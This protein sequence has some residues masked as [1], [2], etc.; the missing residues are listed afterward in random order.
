MAEEWRL[1][2]WPRE[3]GGPRIAESGV[4]KGSGEEE[5][6]QRATPGGRLRGRGR[7]RLCSRFL[8]ASL[9]ERPK[10]SPLRAPRVCNPGRAAE[11]TVTAA[12]RAQEGW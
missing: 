5:A 12:G 7:A 10:V 4:V 3:Q 8:R 11:G 2:G 1:S 6:L 9:P